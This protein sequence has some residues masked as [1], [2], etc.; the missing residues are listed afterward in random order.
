M[1][2]HGGTTYDGGPALATTTVC[3]RLD[4]ARAG[5]A[6][7]VARSGGGSARGRWIRIGMQWRQWSHAEQGE[8][9]GGL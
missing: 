6:S 1:L 2:G 4:L 8:L 7:L 9:A 5:G 3:A